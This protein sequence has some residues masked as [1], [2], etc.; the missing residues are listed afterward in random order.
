LIFAGFL[1]MDIFITYQMNHQYRTD[2][3]MKV[4]LKLATLRAH[5][6]KE[7]IQNLLLVYGTANFIS[8]TPD[9]SQAQFEQYAKGVMA[10]QNLLKNLGAAPDFV[11]KYIYP[12]DGNRQMLGVD[13]RDLADQWTLVKKVLETGDMVVAGPINLV[14]GGRG[15]IGRAPVFIRTTRP[16]KFWGVVSAVIDVDRL[17]ENVGIDNLSDLDIAIRGTDGAGNRGDVFSGDSSL[18]D[19][20]KKAVYMTATFPSG[21]WQ[22]AARPKHG[23]LVWHPFSR[24]LHGVM[25]LFYLTV[26]FFVFKAIRKN[27]ELAGTIQS[28]KLVELA[29]KKEERKMRAMLEASYDAYIMIDDQE[30]IVFWSPAAEKMFGWT[31]EEAIGRKVHSLIAPARYHE[32][33]VKGIEQ[34]ARTGQGRLLNSILELE[35]CRKSGD[36]FPVE[37]TVAA[38]RSDGRYYAVSN[39]RDIT[40][41]KKAEKE[42]EKLAT[43]DSLTG[44]ANRGRFMTLA[45]AEIERTRRYAR[46]LSIIMMD[47]DRFKRINDTHG[48]DVGDKVLQA[49]AAVLESVLRST[50]IAGRIGGEEFALMLPETGLTEAVAVAERLRK[51]VE[52]KSIPVPGSESVSC[53]VSIGVT[54]M[55]GKDPGIDDLLKRADEALYQAKASGRNRVETWDGHDPH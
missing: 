47:A 19:P 17:F 36:C 9:L 38:F 2:Q 11:M 14:Q 44:L 50:D 23:W 28:R 32:E 40:A 53:T 10:G 39:V 33:A 3:E 35:A 13:Y 12:Q 43:T 41:R 7:I 30:K 34:F 18:F 45:A 55:Q 16:P 51:T 1:A 15:L 22:M 49:L 29:L 37:M 48:H 31:S 54:E 21:S 46:P 5:I 42:L 26:V 20:S 24:V 27:H 4:S 25:A 52:Q 6:E 8:V